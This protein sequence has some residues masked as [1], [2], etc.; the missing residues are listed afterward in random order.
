MAVG[1]AL[2]STCPL[3]C[4]F[5]SRR[6]WLHSTRPPRDQTPFTVAAMNDRDQ[7]STYAGCRQSAA[8]ASRRQALLL[9]TAGVA[10]AF[11]A[12]EA[13]A[14]YGNW[15]NE[16]AAVGSC[17]IGDDGDE[18]RKAALFKDRA[19]TQ[20][21]MYG[22][23]SRQGQ[24]GDAITQGVPVS[25]LD[26]EYGRSTL[27]LATLIDK[28]ASLDLYDPERAKVIAQIKKDGST[29]V[30][31]Y[32]RGGSARKQAARKMYIVVDALQGHFAANGFAPLAPAKV[33]KVMD[34]VEES[35]RL[36][37]AGK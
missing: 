33:K 34:N 36:L 15:D 19:N 13:L 23:M 12:D 37:A 20:G 29:W 7:Q 17:A 22:T 3:P 24:L 18:C 14:R 32:A 10:A 31:K 27:A 11:Q 2:N 21:S 9:V 5:T 1:T 6:A 25:V 4:T 8:Q 35:K 28:F 26:D 30:S 16:S